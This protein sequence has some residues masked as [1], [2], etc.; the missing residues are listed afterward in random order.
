MR[1]GE[2]DMEGFSELES[3][4]RHH[5]GELVAM[6]RSIGALRAGLR[7]L[8]VAENTLVWFN[9]DN[10]GLNGQGPGT[11][12]GLRG[13]KGSMYEGGLRVPCV[14]EWPAG[15]EGGR[16]SDFPCSTVDIFPT[17]VALAGLD[18]DA[19]MLSPR[20]GIDLRPL[21]RGELERREQAMGFRHN[22]RGVWMD[23]AYKYLNEK[24]QESLYHL[25]RD[26]AESKDLKSEEPVVLQRMR[27]AYEAWNQTVEASMAGADYPEG[28]VA[29]GQPERRF[30][31]DDPAYQV[32][33]DALEERPEYRSWIER[34][35]KKE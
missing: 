4:I 19:V 34:A 21:F 13:S 3:G 16:V 27:V 6:D 8:G 24:G 7:E 17:L 1:A 28:R 31:I 35:R 32:H 33:F 26:P 2:E 5:L 30:W 22:G 9:S 29:P 18:P 10:G 15:I 25:E 12:G 20:D 23:N 11:M 14:V